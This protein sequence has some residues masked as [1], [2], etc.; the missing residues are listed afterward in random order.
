MEKIMWCVACPKKW[1]IHDEERD[2]VSEPCCTAG[3]PLWL[4]LYTHRMQ[5]KC[6]AVFRKDNHFLI[7]EITEAA[8]S[9][10]ENFKDIYI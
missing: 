8:D 9:S 4:Q 7:W 5:H 1:N 3:E 6:P 2:D 10:K